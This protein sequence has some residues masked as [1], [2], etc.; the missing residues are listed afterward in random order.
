MNELDF[1]FEA[2]AWELAMDRL[3]AGDSLSAL[4]F[5]TLLEGEDEAVVEDALQELEDKRICLDI[6]ELPRNVE[7]GEAAARLRQERTLV[8]QGNLRKGLEKSD[9]LRLYLEEVDGLEPVSDVAALAEKCAS[10]DEAAMAALTNGYLHHV[11]AL[12]QAQVGRGVLLL[13]LIQEGSLGLWQAVLNWQGGNFEEEAQW[14]IRQNMA[15]LITLQARANGVGQKMKKALED[16][17]SA[18][19]ELLT[20]L[21]R[22]PTL[23]EIAAELHISPEAADTVQQMLQSAQTVEKAK[24]QPKEDPVEAEQAVEDTAYF[25]MRQRI[26]DMLSSLEELDARILT[27]RFGLEGGLPMSPEETGKRLQ[28]TPD[29]VVRRETAALAKLRNEG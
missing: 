28:L 10:G 9:P 17:Q 21:G 6:S 1:S 2:S 24:A 29:E 25:Q 27:M 12:A 26:L 19:R 13:D 14:W 20:R 22:N 23:E 4:R 16:F 8:E 11:V 7:S 3:G 5:L 15:K 18:D